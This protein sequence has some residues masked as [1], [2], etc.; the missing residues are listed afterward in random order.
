MAL[1]GDNSFVNIIANLGTGIARK[2]LEKRNHA[3]NLE[4]AI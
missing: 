1:F 3:D 4:H 2:D